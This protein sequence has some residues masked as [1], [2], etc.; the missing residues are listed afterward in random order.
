[1]RAITFDG[2]YVSCEGLKNVFRV[3]N[4]FVFDNNTVTVCDLRFES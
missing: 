4:Y 1:M 3:F 2:T